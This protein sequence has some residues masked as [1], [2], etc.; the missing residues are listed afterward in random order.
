MKKCAIFGHRNINIT[1]DLKEKLKNT[2]NDLILSENVSV[3]IFGSKS[4]FDD[5]CYEIITS[6][7]ETYPHIR[8]IQIRAEYPIISY[9]YEK[10]LK[11]FY[12]NSFYYDNNLKT[13]KLSY[14][15]RNEVIINQCDI[16]LCYCDFN[17][18]RPKSN[19]GTHLAY[20]YAVK[21]NKP[22]INLFDN[23]NNF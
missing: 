2:I 1:N 9:E 5:L 15:K 3:F 6:F 18:S 14:I 12:E 11:S 8:R 21:K 16:C 4:Q 20:K 10:Y 17:Y 19:S 22:I 23:D 7:K 13:G